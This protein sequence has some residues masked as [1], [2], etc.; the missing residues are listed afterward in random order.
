ME[1]IFNLIDNNSKSQVLHQIVN[2]TCEP[3]IFYNFDNFLTQ[4]FLSTF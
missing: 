1:N 4:S 3:I 2:L